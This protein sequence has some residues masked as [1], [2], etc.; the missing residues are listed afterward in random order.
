MSIH[1][2]FSQLTFNHI[3]GSDA[4][5]VGA[6]HPQDI[7]STHSSVSAENILQGVVESVAHV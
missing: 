5:V 6:W 7:I 2:F 3:L 1:P 4:G